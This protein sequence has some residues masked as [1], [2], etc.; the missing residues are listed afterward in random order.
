MVVE[1]YRLRISNEVAKPRYAFRVVTRDGIVKWVEIN[2]ALIEWQGRPATLNFLT[3]IT[4]RKRAEEAL[5]EEKEF[6]EGL[7]NTAQAIIL[8]RDIQGR[9][10]MINPY[11]EEISGYRLDEVRGK[12]WFETFLPESDWQRNR[13]LFSVVIS[14]TKTKTNINPIVTKDGRE[15]KV[16]W[17]DKALHD[18]SGKVTGLLS[19]GQDITKRVRTE[20]DLMSL[21]TQMEFILGA[22][23]TGL[24]IIDAEFNIHYIDPVWQKVY[25]D[26]AGRKCYDYFMERDNVC[27]G[28]GV[29]KALQTK[30]PVLTEEVL[31]KENSRPIQV[32]TIPF[33]N[34]KGK[35][36]VAEVNVDITERKRMEE[37]LQNKDIL[38]GGVA[39][40]T[41]ILLTETDLN[42]AINQTLELLGAATRADRVYIFENHD[43][44]TGEHLAS[45]RYEW[46][47][48]T[49][50]SQ[51]EDPYLQNRSY[52][53]DMPRLYQVLSGGH[54]IKGLVRDLPEP[55][56]T[57]LE[58][59]GTKSLLVIPI[60][61]EAK[62][63]GF[64]GFN[65]CHSERIWTGIEGS[66]L[67][68]AA[69]S[70]GVAIARRHEEDELRTAKDAAESADKAKSEFLAN[71][72]HEIRTPMNAVI[73]LADL[74]ME[75]DL[76][77]EQRNY[78]EMIRSSG[79]SL[80]SVINDI[81]DFSK[82]DSAK[83]ELE[84]RPFDL[85][86]CVEASLNL[87]RPIASKKGLNLTYSIDRKHSSGN[88]WRSY[89][90]STSLNQS[91]Q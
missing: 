10:V 17:F 62:F 81:L 72:S 33:Q 31:V 25:G 26:P 18:N 91:A 43:S 13:E 80:L 74:L 2:A 22:T 56:R 64:I 34:D 50:I 29:L 12:D 20:E 27:P 9:I 46:A 35:W 48:E 70:I 8:V 55:E 84:S 6:S 32:T 86:M 24:D 4:E 3:D 76:T 23:K 16:E 11:F 82:I 42:H 77:E 39:V 49:A 83:M 45:L 69:A 68:A 1:N 44:K 79:D 90:A 63:W 78:L 88:Y 37:V 57:L 52:S 59:L 30:S 5:R 60:M 85:K 73:G 38:L 7:I 28:C 61:I 53:K 51:K 36:L 14:G 87:M 75:T 89:Q 19:I 47:R 40:A 54:P 71:M 41:N 21:K 65:D 67:H 15:I 66:I 58:P